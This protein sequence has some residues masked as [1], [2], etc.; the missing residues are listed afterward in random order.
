MNGFNK[1]A[2][3]NNVTW[4]AIS[5]NPSLS[6]VCLDTALQV[7]QGK[8]VKKYIDGTKQMTGTMEF[9]DANAQ[10]TYKPGLSDQLPLGPTFLSD[11]ELASAGFGK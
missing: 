3:D 6:K 5:Y 2:I 1:L 8:P 11:A 7:L 4:W 9:S 10:E